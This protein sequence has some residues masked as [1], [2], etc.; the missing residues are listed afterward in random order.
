MAPMQSC[1]IDVAFAPV[2]PGQVSGGVWLHNTT[3]TPDQIVTFYGRGVDALAGS[4]TLQFEPSGVSFGAQIVGTTSPPQTLTLR[5]LGPSPLTLKALVLNG[6]DAL[7]F[8]ASGNCALGV[9]IPAGAACE[10]YFHFTPSAAGTRSARLNVD[11]PQLANLTLVSITGIAVA[12]APSTVDVVEFFA[13]S[14][15]Q[16]VPVLAGRIRSSVSTFLGWMSRNRGTVTCAM[17]QGSPGCAPWRG[18]RKGR[19]SAVRCSWC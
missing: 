4:A 18:S 17:P 12:S 7:D 10:L 11:S 15:R 1:R 19:C 16:R 6:A 9:A 2:V 8:R 5:N 14:S 13:R 3:T